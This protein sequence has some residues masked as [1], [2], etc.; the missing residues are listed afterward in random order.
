LKN[1]EKIYKEYDIKYMYKM[2][3]ESNTT[4]TETKPEDTI[5]T[6]E[7]QVSS[8]SQVN[9][10]EENKQPKKKV[11]ISLPG[12]NFSSK[13][14][15]SWSNILI[16]LWSSNKYDIAIST[17]TGSFVSFVRMQT[18]GLD[19]LRGKDQKPFNGEP[20]DVWVTIDSDIIFTSEQVIELI[21]NTTVHPVVSGLYRMQDLQN[22]AV[23]KTWDNE[24]FAKNGTFEFL[25][26]EKLDAWKKETELK[27]MPVSYTGLGFFAC[28]KEVLD[29]MEY[30][31]FNGELKEINGENGVI[32]RDISSEDVNFCN[33]ITKA[34]FEVVINTELRVGHM[35]KLII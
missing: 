11:I 18:L 31:Y 33:N 5:D 24:Y 22:F 4:I 19:V 1:V 3:Q 8:N 17:G 20:Y 32:I 27:Y 15:I 30:P 16:T 35:K 6:S 2:E 10:E 14:L 12:D 29:K 13:F 7:A 9:T 26:Q 23:V 34:G 28:R 21:E 25:N